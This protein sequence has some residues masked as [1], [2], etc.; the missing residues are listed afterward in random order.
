M[1]VRHN[2]E[3]LLK[4]IPAGVKLVAVSK[5]MPAEVILEAY[6]AGQLRFAENKSQELTSKQPALPQDIKWHFIGHLQ[7]NKVK[8]IASFVDMIQSVDSLKLLK[9]IEKEAAKNDRIIDCLLQFHIAMEETKFGLDQE[10]ALAILNS[11]AYK[12]CQHIAIK[13][14]MGMASFSDDT[15]LVRSEFRNLRK[16]FDRLRDDYF[17][18][19]PR[20]CEIS[21]GM[22][23]DYHI[24]I[25]EGSTIVR[26]GTSI[27]GS[28]KY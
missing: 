18:T 22:S 17:G 1:T 7:T 10:E 6:N 3:Y 20:F 15:A 8:Y 9:E 26:L 4:E 12:E 19:D 5:T 14:V 25:E 21:M 2:L 11:P 16:I 24:A 28:R 23:G 13:G 27:F